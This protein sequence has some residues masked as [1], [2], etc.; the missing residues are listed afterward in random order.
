MGLEGMKGHE[1]AEKKRPRSEPW[2]ALVLEQEKKYKLCSAPKG[3]DMKE[4]SG[5]FEVWTSSIKALSE[6]LLGVLETGV[7][8]RSTNWELGWHP[9]RLCL[10][11]SQYLA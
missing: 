5:V 3:L 2:T 1:Q 8:P 11:A 10:L 6:G 4:Y 7:V 9:I